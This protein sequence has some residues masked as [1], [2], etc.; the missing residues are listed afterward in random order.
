MED[1][2]NSQVENQEL[3]LN[4]MEL[5][6]FTYDVLRHTFQSEPSEEFLIQLEKS[7]VD[8]QFPFF[9]HNKL[10][11]QGIRE[12][13]ESLAKSSEGMC[14]YVL[15]DLRADYTQLFVGPGVLKAPPWESAYASEERLLFQESTLDVRKT[16]LKY[17]L[18]SNGYPREA[19]DHIAL[20]LDFMKNM[21]LKTIDSE[22]Y[23]EIES[24]LQE[25]N[26]F[27]KK[28]LLWWIPFFSGDIVS[29]SNSMFY[30]GMARLLEGF[31]KLDEKLIESYIK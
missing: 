7:G 22:A 6:L 29:R 4:L 17:E 18:I 19:D 23:E 24:L 30:R 20:E 25:Q 28:H 3:F 21:I 15:E 27:L 31:L 12:L 8:S 1:F 10:I 16:Y 5:R 11:E 9:K 26:S 13:S 14:G 2:E